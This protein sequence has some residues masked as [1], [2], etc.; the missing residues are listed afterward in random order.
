MARLVHA[1]CLAPRERSQLPT[2]RSVQCRIAVVPVAVCLLAVVLFTPSASV[3]EDAKTTSAASPADQQSAEAHFRKALTESTELDFV[4]T[5]L[6]DVIEHIAHKHN[7][8]VM[9]DRPA[10]DEEGIAADTPVT[11]HL[12]G[13]SLQSALQLVL[14]ELQLTYMIR[15]EV[16]MITTPAR[17]EL[18]LIVRVYPVQ[19]LVKTKDPN[20]KVD[21]DYDSLAEL[22][23]STVE[24]TTWDDV[25]G[26]GSVRP[27]RGALVFSQTEP[28]HDQIA[29]LL[30][31]LRKLP[32]FDAREAAKQSDR[33]AAKPLSVTPQAWSDAK[34]RRAL[35][36]NTSLEYVETPLTDVLDEISRKHKI[37]IWLD[38]PDL[39]EEGIA[40]DIP[41]TANLKNISL[42][43]ALRLL[44]RDSQLTFQLQ[45]ET[46]MITTPARAETE[47]KTIIYNVRDLLT[48]DAEGADYEPLI[49]L[50][51]SNVAPTTWDEVGGPGSLR[52]YTQ[53]G[54]LV[55]SQTDE[56]HR[57]IADLLATL[58]R[59]PLSDPEGEKRSPGDIVTKIYLY[60]PAMITRSA[61]VVP[62][63][64]VDPDRLRR[65]ITSLVDPDSWA[66]P[67][68][69]LSVLPGRVIVKHR[70]ETQEKVA[71]LLT[72]LG[73]SHS[74]QS[75]GGGVG[76]GGGRGGRGG[77]G[78]S[79]GFGGGGGLGGRGI[80]AF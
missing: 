59:T 16:L 19:D 34:L 65:V 14:R 57:E 3:A 72:D 62:R 31:G 7:L 36:E 77:F 39:E 79:G 52:G 2:E 18:E 80:G 26:P 43:S 28:V 38:R 41:V 29:L 51:V 15:D 68:Y 46:L 20:G 30:S 1:L 63:P 13:V 9:L 54:A 70:R 5:P 10:L 50:A 45:D 32:A 75:R 48:L 21:Y 60:M 73:F 44:L 67:K 53:R 55:V 40:P 56:V 23:L 64:D 58:R 78:G 6:I 27:Y 4:E 24:P 11:V 66:D 12:S 8:R 37:P 17:A 42:R 71:K 35:K 22:I 25:G 61:E 69:S 49:D 74:G 33:E 76:V 47:L